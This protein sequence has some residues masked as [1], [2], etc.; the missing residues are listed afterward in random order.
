VLNSFL[1]GIDALFLVSD[2]DGVLADESLTADL[3]ARGFRLLHETDSIALRAAFQ[4]A[5]PVTIGQPLIV[6]TSGPLNELPYDLG[7]QGQHVTLA[8]HTFFPRLDYP[9]IRQLSPTQRARLGEVYAQEPPATPL[10]SSAT[11]AWLL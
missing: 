4:R 5:Q 7:Q 9:T 3:T 10:S 6:I 2:P 1:P 11:V 8:L